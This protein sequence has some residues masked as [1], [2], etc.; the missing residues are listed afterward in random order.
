MESSSGRAIET[1]RPFSNV[2]RC[3]W[4]LVMNVISAVSFL[5]KWRASDD[6]QNQ[7]RKAVV[8]AGSLMNHGANRGHVVILRAA[9][10][11]VGHQ[12]LRQCGDEGVGAAQKGLPQGHGSVHC[13]SVGKNAGSVH[14]SVRFASN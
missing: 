4:S 9:A 3:R 12:L 13:A 11:R 5:L 7:R 14:V 8:V 1:P 6:S 10:Q 2:R